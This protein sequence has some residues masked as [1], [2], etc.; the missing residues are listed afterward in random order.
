[1]VFLNILFTTYKKIQNT[2]ACIV[3]HISHFAHITPILKSLLWLPILYRINFKI[4]CFTHRAISLGE[5]YYLR[6]LL[7]NRLNSHSLRSSFFNP[8]VVPCFKTVYN[9]IRSFSYA[10]TLFWNHLPNATRSA[11]TFMS[12]RKKIENLFI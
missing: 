8:L 5:L 12:F 3:T 7:S 11:L 10:A 6:S 1:M 4:C 9:G 2:I